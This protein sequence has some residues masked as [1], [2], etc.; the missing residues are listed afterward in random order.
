MRLGVLVSGG[1]TNL[2]AILDAVADGRL[3]AEVALV[4]SDRPGVK[5]LDRAAAA[6]VPSVVLRV[7]DYADRDAYSAAVADALTAQGVDTVVFAGFVKILTQPMLDAYGG[8]MVN[9]HPALL[10][11]FGGPGMYGLAV[12]QAVL[13]YG[14][15][16]SGCSVHFVDASVDGGPLIEQVTVPVRD[17]DTAETLQQRILVAEHLALVRVLGWLGAGRVRIEGRRVL[18]QG[19]DEEG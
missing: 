9:T 7:R 19:R 16:V 15:R 5:A 13:D 18:V 1:G 11:S 12:H 3:A 8:R 2:Q 6:G 17:D 10:P 14:C 4:V